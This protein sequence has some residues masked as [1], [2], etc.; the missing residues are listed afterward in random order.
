MVKELCASQRLD[1][2]AASAPEGWN[3]VTM[4]PSHPLLAPAPLPKTAR[5]LQGLCPPRRLVSRHEV[6]PG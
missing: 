2:K 6:L 1:P 5:D 3:P 4:Y